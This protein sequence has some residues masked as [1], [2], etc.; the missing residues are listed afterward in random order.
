LNILPLVRLVD[1]CSASNLAQQ[2]GTTSE[3]D[4]RV[5]FWEEKGA[6]DGEEAGEDGDECGDPAPAAGFA[7][8]ATALKEGLEP[9]FGGEGSG[10]AHDRTNSGAEE[11]CGG[12]DGHSESTLFSG[13]QIRDGTTK[14]EKV[15]GELSS[16]QIAN[17]FVYE[18]SVSQGA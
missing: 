9:C 11:R 16:N 18:P 7:E 14:N 8:E 13:E 4:D 3:E 12:E 1:V 10:G 5:G 2:G 6:D 15:D 17:N